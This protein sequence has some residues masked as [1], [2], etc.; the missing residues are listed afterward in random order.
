MLDELGLGPSASAR[1]RTQGRRSCASPSDGDLR[2]PRGLHAG[3]RAAHRTSFCRS[4][5]SW[6]CWPP[7]PAST[8]LHPAAATEVTGLLA[9]RRPRRGVRYRTRRR[10]QR[11]RSG[12]RSPSRAT[13]AIRWYA[14]SAGCAHGL[15]A[16][17]W[18]SVVPDPARATRRRAGLRAAA[19]RAASSLIDR[20]DYL[21]FAVRDRQ[22]R[23]TPVR[24]RGSTASART[25]PR[26]SRPRRPGR[27]P[28]L[29]GRR[30]ASDVRSTGCADGT[31][32][33]AVHRRRRARDVAGR[34]G[35]HQPGRAGR[36]GRGDPA[37]GATAAGNGDPEGSE[38]RPQTADPATA[39]VQTVQRLM[40]RGL[41]VPILE[42]RRMSP[43]T[44]VLALLR[45]VP[46]LSSVPAYL[47]GVG[48][49]AGARAGLRQEIRFRGTDR[50]PC[51]AHPASAYALSRPTGTATARSRRAR[52]HPTRLAHAARWWRALDRAGPRPP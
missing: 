50:A 49:S 26:S 9:A 29:V 35:R 28:R 8:H 47:I 7:R 39:A 51:H 19:R 27:R 31:A 38:G 1:C 10:R 21:Q 36:R 6:S 12:P 18:T 45:R 40:H 43:P 44:P 33:A 4:G 20:G 15:T 42:G 16:P 17:R 24:G 41:V 22:G 23:P 25:S 37:R 48:L 46:Q 32:R 3:C 34:R 5:T 30:Q 52:S 2:H 14:G 13:A 11:S